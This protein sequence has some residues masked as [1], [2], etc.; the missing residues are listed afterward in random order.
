MAFEARAGGERVALFDHPLYAWPHARDYRRLIQN[1][2][3]QRL[4]L[5]AISRTETAEDAQDHEGPCTPRRP[6]RR[7]TGR[8]TVTRAR[9]V[10][11]AP[12][13]P[14]PVEP[15]RVPARRFS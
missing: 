12:G 9:G 5:V 2:T 1:A 8:D 15:P 11:P 14:G 7:V 13:P 6:R 3:G 10:P 4:Q